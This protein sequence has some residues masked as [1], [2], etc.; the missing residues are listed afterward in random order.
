VNWRSRGLA[1]FFLTAILIGCLA[2]V[3]N[4]D[5]AAVVGTSVVFEGIV[6]GGGAVECV[7]YCA[8]PLPALYATKTDDLLVDRNNNGDADP[9]DTLRYRML[10]GNVSPVTM[11]GI[12]YIERL[13]PS[14]SFVLDSWVVRIVD[15]DGNI[16]THDVDGTVWTVDA[17]GNLATGGDAVVVEATADQEQIEVFEGPVYLYWHVGGLAPDEFVEFAFD[18]L[19]PK[20]LPDTVA[21][22]LAQASV[23][24]ETTSPVV[25]D[26]PSTQYLQ[27]ATWTPLRPEP[28]PLLRLAQA[29]GG[30]AAGTANLA[31]LKGARVL[32]EPE[33]E[34]IVE[35]GGEVEYRVLYRNDSS[36]AI[37]D[38]QLVDLVGPHLSVQSDSV[39]P[40]TARIHRI[41]AVELMVAEYERLEPGETA[42]LIYRVS[43]DS[44]LPPEIGYTASRALASAPGMATGLTDDAATQLLADPTAVLFPCECVDQYWTWDDWLKAVSQSPTGLFPLVMQ[45]KDK[46]NH[47]RWVLYG[48]DFFGDLSVEPSVRPPLWPAWALVGLVDMERGVSPTDRPGFRLAQRQEEYVKAFLESEPFFLWANFDIPLYGR[49]PATNNGELLQCEGFDQFFCNPMYLPLLA[50][51][52][53]ARDWDMR[54]LEDDLIVA[55]RMDETELPR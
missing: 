37:H 44:W 5:N 22:L 46:S 21:G 41:G 23:Y 11:D 29:G 2:R 16:Q 54:W 19:I 30:G 49:V 50:T 24:C 52:D 4:A 10:L 8:P 33:V 6:G 47:L 36:R 51:L 15:A 14:V 20:D 13:D 1:A 18:V 9:G 53:W 3:G 40:Q 45:E 17:E 31:G 32:N 55:T 39:Q 25:T 28:E 38:L 12:H 27:D 42:E 7:P 26:D 35:P 48:A 43:V 34:W